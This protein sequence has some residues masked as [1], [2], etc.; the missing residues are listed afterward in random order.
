MSVIFGAFAVG[1]SSSFLPDF[2]EG[3][4]ATNRLFKLIDSVP[5]IDSS[6]PDGTVIVSLTNF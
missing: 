3:K 6:N 5:K 4:I 1:Q 2:A